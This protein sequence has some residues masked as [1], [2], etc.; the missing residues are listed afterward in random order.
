MQALVYHGP[1]QKVFGNPA[2]SAAL[3][4]VLTRS[5]GGEG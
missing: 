1:G 3:K 2:A 4:V 5:E